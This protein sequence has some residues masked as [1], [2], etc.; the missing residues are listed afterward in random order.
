MLCVIFVKFYSE[1]GMSD[2][3]IINNIT[4]TF[5]KN[6]KVAVAVADGTDR[7]RNRLVHRDLIVE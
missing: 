6:Y 7:L 2:K 1:L 5:S 4:Q 3:I